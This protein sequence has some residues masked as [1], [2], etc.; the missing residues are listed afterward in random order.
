MRFIYWMLAF[1]LVLIVFSYKA[2]AKPEIAYYY[3]GDTVKILDQ[4]MSYK[5]RINHIDAPERNQ[6]YGKKSRRALMQL[7]QNKSV[8][9][10]ITGV[11]HYQRQLGELYCDQ[12]NASVY[13]LKNGY[14]W[15]YTR[16]SN[17]RDFA[18]IEQTARENKLGLWQAKKPLAPWIWRKL[19]AS[20]QNLSSPTTQKLQKTD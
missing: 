16:Y 7:C 9:V 8:K 18:A 3:D 6:S 12:E 14:A 11:D 10:I 20:T 1:L 13:M 17:M 5:L 2:H 19:N 15:F 4:N